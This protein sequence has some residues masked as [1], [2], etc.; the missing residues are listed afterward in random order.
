MGA[1]Q[2]VDRRVVRGAREEDEGEA[3]ELRALGRRVDHAVRRRAPSVVGPHLDQVARVDQQRAG[4]GRHPVPAAVSGLCLQPADRRVLPQDGEAG[5]VRVRAVAHRA[6]GRAR[7]RH[8]WYR[9][10]VAEAQVGHGLRKAL[11]EVVGG[12]GERGGGQAHQRV[13]QRDHRVPVLLH[14]ALELRRLGGHRHRLERWVA[15][16]GEDEVLDEVGRRPAVARAARYGLDS[17]RHVAAGSVA[18]V[19]A[20][21]H[22]ALTRC[23][24]E[25]QRE[26]V[27]AL[28]DLRR[29]AMPNDVRHAHRAHRSIPLRS[30]ARALLLV[31]AQEIR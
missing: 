16:V 18:L 21:A 17:L 7:L 23:G 20:V 2:R 31:A 28:D 24:E 29:N 27:E 25:P 19:E 26:L 22:L 8:G 30:D 9:G 11:L 6:V 14:G 4:P 10:V 12:Q 3:A 1:R 5:V 15:S 13:Q